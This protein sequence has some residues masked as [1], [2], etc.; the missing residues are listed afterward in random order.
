VIVWGTVRPRNSTRGSDPTWQCIVDGTDTAP[1]WVYPNASYS[2]YPYCY[3][4]NLSKGNHTL[5]F[6]TI[7]QSETLYVDAVQYQA[8]ATADI[9]NAWTETDQSDGRIKYSPGWIT[10]DD[11]YR[12]WTYT[13]GAWLTFDFNGVYFLSCRYETFL[14]P[15]SL[16]R[17]WRHLGRL[18]S[19]QRRCHCWRGA[20]CD[21]WGGVKEEF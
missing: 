4:E 5:Q 12:K 6:N 9:G 7:I 18:H 11:D 10:D 1:P 8:S 19:W 17:N 16:L 2:H 20:V 3:G 13:P 21:R 15:H 14:N